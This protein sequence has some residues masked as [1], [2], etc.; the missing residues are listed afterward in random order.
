MRLHCL[1]WSICKLHRYYLS[2]YFADNY[3]CDRKVLQCQ[4]SKSEFLVYKSLRGISGQSCLIFVLYIMSVGGI[5]VIMVSVMQR[6]AGS[7][8]RCLLQVTAIF[9]LLV[10]LSRKLLYIPP[11]QE[12]RIMATETLVR[13]VISLYKD[14]LQC[15][16]CLCC[17]YRFNIFRVMSIH[18]KQKCCLCCLSQFLLVFITNVCKN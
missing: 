4:K 10:L 12:I 7:S 6:K 15:L 13:S 17:Y 2:Y 5:F 16:Y 18:R 1:Q 8:Q 9:T 3:F 11:A 14:L